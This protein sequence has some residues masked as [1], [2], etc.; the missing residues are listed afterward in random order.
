MNFTESEAWSLFLHIYA[1]ILTLV[2][3]TWILALILPGWGEDEVEEDEPAD[4]PPPDHT[5]L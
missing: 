3:I 4:L 1:A 5:H 2:F